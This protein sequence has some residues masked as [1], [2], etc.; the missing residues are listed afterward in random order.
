MEHLSA[1]ASD[2]LDAALATL[3]VSDEHLQRSLLQ[4]TRRRL[5]EQAG[6]LRAADRPAEL[7]WLE[8]HA[9]AVLAASESAADLPPALAALEGTAAQLRQWRPARA[10][11]DP[12]ETDPGE[13]EARL[14]RARQAGRAAALGRTVSARAAALRPVSARLA[15]LR[16]AE[17][18]LYRRLM[19]LQLLQRAGAPPISGHLPQLR[20]EVAALHRAVTAL[21]QKHPDCRAAQVST[22][23]PEPDSIQL[24]TARFAAAYLL[25]LFSSFP[26]ILI[27]VTSVWPIGF[28]HPSLATK[29]LSKLCISLCTVFSW[30]SLILAHY[31]PNSPVNVVSRLHRVS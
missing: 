23:R 31:V 21:C 26:V 11:A 15:A 25:T 1:V 29:L 18:A 28:H 2:E 7:A 20:A 9:S 30:Y 17:M 5:A 13:T 19:L 3:T 8:R 22:P 12:E 6:R 24:Q 10:E 14:E 4:Q 16:A 27:F